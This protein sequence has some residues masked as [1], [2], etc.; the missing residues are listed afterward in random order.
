M[1]PQTLMPILRLVSYVHKTLDTY[2]HVK[3]KKKENKQALP[4]CWQ[5]K[6]ITA[7]LKKHKIEKKNLKIKT[8]STSNEIRLKIYM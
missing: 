5:K 8:K 7:I 3:Q 4:P 2:V 1:A 6:I